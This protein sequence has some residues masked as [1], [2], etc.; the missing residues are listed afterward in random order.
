MKLPTFRRLISSDYEKQFQKLIDTLSIS[1]NNG[2]EVLYEA[3]N[4]DLTLRENLSCTVKDVTVT[5]DINGKPLQTASFTLNS[6]AKVD[7]AIV[8]QALNQTNTTHFPLA[9]VFVSGAQSSGTFIINNIAG[10]QPNEQYVL[11]IVAFQQ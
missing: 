5:V 4:G 10:L 3:L 6:T 8:I 9:G 11:R 1:L 2:I 7:G